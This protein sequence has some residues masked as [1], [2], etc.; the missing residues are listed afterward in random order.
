MS[1]SPSKASPTYSSPTH[2]DARPT[3]TQATSPDRGSEE[4][5]IAANTSFVAL[6]AAPSTAYDH[7]TPPATDELD[8]K[9]FPNLP[10]QIYEDPATPDDDLCHTPST[11]PPILNRILPPSLTQAA[12]RHVNPQRQRSPNIARASR[13]SRASGKTTQR[14]RFQPYSTVE[15]LADQI[16]ATHQRLDNLVQ[17]KA[18]PALLRETTAQLTL[19]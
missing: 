18:D 16:E 6:A 12:P 15:F 3:T 13:N 4:E 5:A 1:T 14:V 19:L 9:H 11:P 17:L 8:P 7:T 2:L 10:F